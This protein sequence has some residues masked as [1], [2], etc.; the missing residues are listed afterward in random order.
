MIEK[1]NKTKERIYCNSSWIAHSQYIATKPRF[2]IEPEN[3]FYYFNDIILLSYLDVY[4]SVKG[5]EFFLC[6]MHE[7]RDSL[8][9]KND[10][11]QHFP[12]LFPK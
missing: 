10:F 8:F 2:Q 7:H 12:H 6:L 5:F 4:C 9:S 3:Y 11:K 1:G